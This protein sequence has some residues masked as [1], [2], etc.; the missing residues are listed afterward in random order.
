MEAERK[1]K[2]G[3]NALEMLKMRK[4]EDQRKGNHLGLQSPLLKN[5]YKHSTHHGL[6]K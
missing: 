4:K 1:G 5:T 6:A 3:Y 2:E